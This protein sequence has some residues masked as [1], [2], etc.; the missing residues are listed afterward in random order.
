MSARAQGTCDVGP[1]ITVGTPLEGE[2]LS[3]A[4]PILARRKAADLAAWIGDGV[5][6]G[7]GIGEVV[8]RGAGAGNNEKLQ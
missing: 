1:A 6:A 7:E 4:D 5:D 2:Q 3:G 8:G